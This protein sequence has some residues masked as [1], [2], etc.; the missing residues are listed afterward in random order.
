MSRLEEALRRAHTGA[1]EPQRFNVSNARALDWFEVS[2]PGGGPTPVGELELTFART[3]PPATGTATATATRTTVSQHPAATDRDDAHAPSGVA[4]NGP[5]AERLGG[6]GA[7][8]PV[9]VE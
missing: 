5:L 8:P 2:D 4:V 3:D 7:V 6:S 1:A 9:A